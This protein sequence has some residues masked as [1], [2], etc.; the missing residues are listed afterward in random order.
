MKKRIIIFLCIFLTACSS[1]EVSI[2]FQASDQTNCN[3]TLFTVSPI[4]LDKIYSLTPLGMISTPDHVFPAP[5]LYLFLFDPKN[6]TLGVEAPVYAPGN[7]T[8][9]DI[10]LRYYHNL[11]GEEK[12][13]DYTLVFSSSSCKDVQIYFHH[14]HTLKYQPFIDAANKIESSCTFDNVTNEQYC[15]GQTNIPI[16]AGT[17]MATAGDQQAGVYG[18]D[19]GARDARTSGEEE[20]DDS[21]RIC[22]EGNIFSHCHTVCPWAYFSEEIQQ[23]LHFSSEN[24]NGSLNCGDIF[25]SKG[26]AEG[27]WFAKTEQTQSYTDSPEANNLYI[28]KNNLDPENKVFSIGKSIPNTNPDLYAFIPHHEGTINRDPAEIS[29]ETIYC[30]ETQAKMESRNAVFFLQRKDANNLEIEK[31]SLQS[32]E[33]ASWTFTDNAVYFEK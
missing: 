27:Y 1:N 15:Q 25:V 10:G 33:G 30:Y 20:F 17:Y 13:I 5:H 14:I 23:Q 18:L 9:T 22:Q 32:C 4:P 8:L 21:K 31:S 11:N 16:L 26:T 6:K 3:E 12:Y 29:D 2:V 7:I 28:G 19:F 24:G